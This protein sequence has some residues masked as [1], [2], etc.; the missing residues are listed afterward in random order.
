MGWKASFIVI[1]R[2]TD[3]DLTG[4]LAALGYQG[5]T[6]IEDQPFE[7]VINPRK[8]K[9][10]ITRTGDNIILCSPD[11][12]A[13]IFEQRQYA[14]EV[15]LGQLFPESEICFIILHSVINL[16]GYSVSRG[17][18]R[19]RIRAGSADDGTF[20][21]EGEPLP[22][23]LDLLSQ[24]HLTD[25]GQRVYGEGEDQMT[26]D[27]VGEEFAFNICKRY[28]GTR[29]DYADDLFETTLQGYSYSRIKKLAATTFSSQSS[30]SDTAKP[31]WKFW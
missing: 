1:H 10:Y 23:E 2:P 9:V 19:L 6:R 28:F 25:S 20:I 21:D 8:G 7:S 14:A 16:W 13:Q 22:E 18:Q 30:T 24:S 27:Q 31:W 11:I 26:E 4:L 29:L 3:T 12:P 17:G 15:L 5:L